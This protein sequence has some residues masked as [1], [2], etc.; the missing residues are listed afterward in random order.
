VFL[1]ER[2]E[3]VGAVN[4]FRL[5]DSPVDMLGR[6]ERVAATVPTRAREWG[7]AFTHC[8]MPP[9]LVADFNMSSVSH[10]V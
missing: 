6:V 9:L 3:V 7:E 10:S 2:G 8:A 5:N 4:N 1:V